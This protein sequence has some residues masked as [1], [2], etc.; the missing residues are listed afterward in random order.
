MAQSALLATPLIISQL[1]GA[2]SN[3]D[4]NCAKAVETSKWTNM[5]LAGGRHAPARFGPNL[6]PDYL[7]IRHCL[8]LPGDMGES[9]QYSDDLV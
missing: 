8:F 5:L 6:V 3:G 4:D 1:D 7:V 9:V 2:I